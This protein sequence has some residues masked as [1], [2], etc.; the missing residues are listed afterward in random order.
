MKFELNDNLA[1]HFQVALE[2]SGED[3]TKVIERMFKTYVYDVVSRK[4]ETFSGLESFMRLP[5]K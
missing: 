1:E 3:E 2:Q 5:K 4:Q